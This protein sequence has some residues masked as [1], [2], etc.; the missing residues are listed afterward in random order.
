MEQGKVKKSRRRY[1]T[2]TRQS[3][4]AKA[5]PDLLQREFTALRPHQIWTSDITYIWTEEGWLYLAIIL[6]AL[7]PHLLR[8]GGDNVRSSRG[9]VTPPPPESY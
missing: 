6:D 7:P 9:P 8:A 4:T 2:T 1:R 5:A 3:R